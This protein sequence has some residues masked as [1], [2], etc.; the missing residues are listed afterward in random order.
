MSQYLSR[1]SQQ[2]GLENIASADSPAGDSS[3]LPPNNSFSHSFSASSGDPIIPFDNS[4]KAAAQNA[5]DT[6]ETTVAAPST[7]SA[8]N[9]PA[10][11]LLSSYL[12]SSLLSFSHSSE[13]IHPS[14]ASSE[15]TQ[16]S[17]LSDTLF[18][19]LSPQTKSRLSAQARHE[20]PT[21]STENFAREQISFETSLASNTHVSP[22]KNASADQFEIQST[23]DTLSPERMASMPTSALFED[24]SAGDKSDANSQQSASMSLGYLQII[25]AAR[26]WVAQSTAF[27]ISASDSE[28][29]RP[30]AIASNSS[31]AKQASN[32]KHPSPEALADLT[33]SLIANSQ[34]DPPSIPPANR[35]SPFSE[36][37]SLTQ[38][39]ATPVVSIGSIQVTVEAPPAQNAPSYA[40][41]A[42]PVAAP[43]VSSAPRLHR[44]YI[45]PR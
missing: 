24:G 1:L 18:N 9:P 27:A 39:A 15:T 32:S 13:N 7:Q 25:E 31:L 5:L 28:R 6:I 4:L 38:P 41:V 12:P 30:E 16:S 20:L 29:D 8:A 37:A 40:P 42:V 23:D 11:P 26:K 14:Q 21:R 43:V 34:P 35:L 33:R 2:T 45:R 44:H 17:A 22:G 36:S 3:R 10:Q 19:A